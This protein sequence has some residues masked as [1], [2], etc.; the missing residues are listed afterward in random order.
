MRSNGIGDLF[1][2][3]PQMVRDEKAR[4]DFFLDHL[5]VGSPSRDDV[6]EWLDVD[7]MGKSLHQ[8]ALGQTDLD[9][10]A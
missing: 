3:N 9:Q 1:G 4:T 2:G 8:Y 6:I 7:R 5:T 10:T